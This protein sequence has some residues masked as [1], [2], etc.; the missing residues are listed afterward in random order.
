MR[1]DSRR[2]E[3]CLGLRFPVGRTCCALLPVVLGCGEPDVVPP[4]PLD[5]QAPVPYP[6]ALWD[7]GVRG[8][9]AVRTLVNE[10]GRVDSV[11]LSTSS[12]NASLDSA[13]LVGVRELR[14]SPARQGDDAIA[15][16]VMV[17]VLFAPSD[18]TP[19]NAP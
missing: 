19:A 8:E 14:F 11:E 5:D 15:A 17:P 1:S 10:S 7:A 3:A 6:L 13:A 18:T 2:E 12:G 9:P 16:W 4:A